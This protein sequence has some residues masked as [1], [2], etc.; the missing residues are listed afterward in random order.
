MHY[1][2]SNLLYATY[3]WNYRLNVQ[4]SH[5]LS[6]LLDEFLVFLHS[7]D[8]FV[9][10]LDEILLNAEKLMYNLHFL[11]DIDLDQLPTL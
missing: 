7:V 6:H 9:N 2:S 3:G 10:H 1:R 8:V 4:V 5:I 11:V